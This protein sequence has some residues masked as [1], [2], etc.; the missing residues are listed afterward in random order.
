MKKNYHLW[1]LIMLLVTLMSSCASLDSFDEETIKTGDLN[2][3]KHLNED[4][5]ERPTTKRLPSPPLEE[6]P[7]HP[8]AIL[9]NYHLGNGD[10]IS[11]TVFGEPDFSVTSHLSESGTISYPFL[12]E[13]QLSGLTINQIEQQ[14]T[15]GLQGDYLVKPRVTV[16]VLEYR[17]FFVNG[18][19]KS[20]GGYA[21]VPGMTVNKAI[22]LA[23]GLTDIASREE[24]SIIREG[25]TAAA[26]SPVNLKS[27]VGPGEIIIVKEYKK[28]F[29]N[30]AV[31][32]RGSYNFIPDLTVEKAISM[33]GGFNEFASARRSKI[34]II[35]DGDKT[36][37]QVRANLNTPVNPGDIIN[38]EESIF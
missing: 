31:N 8:N 16:T 1:F 9:S 10:L 4:K 25:N 30:G 21:F 32:S 11:I 5:P 19:V 35:R 3:D 28:F 15:E 6:P 13:L 27:Y 26:P 24:I 12:G 22:S 36:A 33:A 2:E 20:P 37:T 29:V 23:G 34:Y 17:K 14:I 7:P 38:V 18:E